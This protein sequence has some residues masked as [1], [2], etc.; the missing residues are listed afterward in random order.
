MKVTAIMMAVPLAAVIVGNGINKSALAQNG[1]VFQRSE[2]MGRVLLTANVMPE[3]VRL[4]TETCASEVPDLRPEA[5]QAKFDW[6]ERNQDALAQ[7]DALRARAMQEIEDESNRQARDELERQL[8]STVQETMETQV[9]GLMTEIKGLEP[10]HKALTCDRYMHVINEQEWDV[11]TLHPD[12]P[13]LLA[14]GILSSSN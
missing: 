13:E 11:M 3:T 7:A 8:N 5:N 6:M 4:V 9:D 1:E 10:D 14:D 12:L 2:R